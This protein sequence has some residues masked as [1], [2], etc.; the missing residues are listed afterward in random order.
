MRKLAQQWKLNLVT[1]FI[2][3]ELL[4]FLFLIQR[5]VTL[6]DNNANINREYTTPW[7]RWEQITKKSKQNK[8]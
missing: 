2:F 1:L 7:L 5:A 3:D 4:S 8:N 6:F